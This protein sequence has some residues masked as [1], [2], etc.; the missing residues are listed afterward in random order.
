MKLWCWDETAQ[1]YRGGNFKFISHIGF[2]L[3]FNIPCPQASSSRVRCMCFGIS[4]NIIAW[5]CESAGFESD[6]YNKTGGSQP[7]WVSEWAKYSFRAHPPILYHALSK[8]YHTLESS[9]YKISIYPTHLLIMHDAYALGFLHISSH[10][11]ARGFDP[12]SVW[13]KYRS[14]KVFSLYC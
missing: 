12:H 14:I 1:C 9:W 4:D 2:M 13:T 8:S 11:L 10:R 5:L 7:V 6:A 3:V